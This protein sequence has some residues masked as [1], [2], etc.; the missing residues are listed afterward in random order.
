MT[1]EGMLQPNR[2]EWVRRKRKEP[3]E[4]IRLD[5]RFVADPE[6]MQYALLLALLLRQNGRATFSKKDMEYDDAEYNIVYTRS[7]DGQHL[8]VNVVSAESG[9][10]RSPERAKQ[11]QTEQSA[12]QNGTAGPSSRWNATE[13]LKQMPPAQENP[14]VFP[15]TGG[16]LGGPLENL[17]N[18]QVTLSWNDWQRWQ[19]AEVKMRE[20]K[21]AEDLYSAG[22]SDS[23][24]QLERSPNQYQPHAQKL[25]V[26]PQPDPTKPQDGSQAYAF[27]FQ[28]GN[29][30][31]TAQKL[32][33]GSLER[34]LLQKDQKLA[35]EEQEA[36]ERQ[37]NQ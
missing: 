31:E 6:R 17:P 33:L 27:P 19:E 16:P 4:P 5:P 11:W 10:I 34:Q 3:S 1:E 25:A 30:P 7:L 28:V 36:I 20:Q 21:L 12:N 26:M 2:K 24:P 18:Q 15:R 8:E 9:I 37:T 35:Q 22:L 32:D 13:P 29:N 23:P 14:P